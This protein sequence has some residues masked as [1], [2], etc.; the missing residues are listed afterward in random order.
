VFKIHTHRLHLAHRLGGVEAEM[1]LRTA[2]T[3]LTNRRY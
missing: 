2:R 3:D 1:L